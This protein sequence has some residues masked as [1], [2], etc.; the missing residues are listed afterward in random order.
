MVN[1]KVRSIVMSEEKLYTLFVAEEHIADDDQVIARGLTLGQIAKAIR[2]R[3]GAA[4]FTTDC[5][6]GTFR[7]FELRKF[8]AKGKLKLVIGATVPASGN[9]V[10]DR[11]AAEKMIDVQVVARCHQFCE[12]RAIPDAEF[13]RRIERVMKR[14]AAKALEEMI[15]TQLV[16]CLLEEGYRI[17][18][19]ARW[20][21]PPFQNS[22]RRDPML[23]LLFDLEIAD[24][25]VSRKGE[26]SWIS[27][28]FGEDGWDVIA[29]YTTDLGYLIDPIVEP[30][31][32]WNKPGSNERGYTV[33]TLPSPER[34]ESGDAEARDAVET[35]FST[36]DRA[37]G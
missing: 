26:S 23:K 4:S 12:Y 20:D 14:R 28:I 32:P 6:Y 22:R 31:L 17:T 3:D 29:D 7:A 18:A 1:R 33:I 21:K 30:H 35:F 27:L 34:L 11:E 8:D 36:I 5:D 13:D 24:L 15:V 37:L 25:V 16:D 10:L 19:C 9:V 2:E